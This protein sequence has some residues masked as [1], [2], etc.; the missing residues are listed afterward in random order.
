MPLL[1]VLCSLVC[2]R[3]VSEGRGGQRQGGATHCSPTPMPS[4]GR[5]RLSFSFVF[6]GA[7]WAL[8]RKQIVRGSRWCTH[9]SPFAPMRRHGGCRL[10]VLFA[11][12]RLCL[13]VG[14]GVVGVRFE[15]T[16]VIWGGIFICGRSFVPCRH[17][18]FSFRCC[19]CLS[20]VG[21]EEGGAGMLTNVQKQRTMNFRCRPLFGCH[22]TVATLS[23]TIPMTYYF[24]S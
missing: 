13:F 5:C 11:S 17:P 14:A 9:R 15:A 22:V 7:P 4:H 10:S 24:H 16:I 2:K 18:I 8:V 21:W 19:L 23:R 6:L 1:Y 3:A 20:E 12:R